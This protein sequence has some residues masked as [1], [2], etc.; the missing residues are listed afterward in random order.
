MKN[1]IGY[2]KTAIIGSPG[3]GNGGAHV[4]DFND[5][6]NQWEQ[7]GEMLVPGVN[8]EADCGRSVAISDTYYFVGCPEDGE[9]G[10]NNSIWIAAS[11]VSL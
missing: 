2:G 4:F 1:L 11:F 7:V 5:S 9:K 10:K 6:N 3:Q 8:N